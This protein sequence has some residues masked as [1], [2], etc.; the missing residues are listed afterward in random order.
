MANVEL[1]KGTVPRVGEI[2]ALFAANG[3]NLEV[4]TTLKDG[5]PF[6]DDTHGKLA[7]VTVRDWT[8]VRKCVAVLIANNYA[9]ALLDTRLEVLSIVD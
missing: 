2:V 1:V 5:T 4:K 7:Y 8:H 3:A 6:H 9:Y